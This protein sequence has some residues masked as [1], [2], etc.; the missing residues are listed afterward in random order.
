M[1]VYITLVVKARFYLIVSKQI[2]QGNTLKSDDF[3]N[4]H[5]ISQILHIA[6]SLC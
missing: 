4:Y 3:L 6:Y 5:K 1:L 2:L